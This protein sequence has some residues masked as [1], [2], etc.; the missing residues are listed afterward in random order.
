MIMRLRTILLVAVLMPVSIGAVVAERARGEESEINYSSYR[1]A[2]N[3]TILDL[4]PSTNPNMPGA[5]GRIVIPGSNSTIDGNQT[6][7]EFQQMGH[8]IP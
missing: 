2:R 1:V 5:T 3:T 6:A 8:Q 7:T 4:Q